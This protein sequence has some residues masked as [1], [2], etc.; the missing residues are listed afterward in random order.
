ML[1]QM[2]S[3]EPINSTFALGG[4]IRNKGKNNTY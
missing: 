1:F 3:T 2:V 4:N